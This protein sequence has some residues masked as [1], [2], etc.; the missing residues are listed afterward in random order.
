MTGLVTT[1][2]EVQLARIDRLILRETQVDLAVRRFE[3][4]LEQP[5]RPRRHPQFA[6]QVVRHHGRAPLAILP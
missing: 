1:P 3:L 4:L 6:R 2:G 5:G